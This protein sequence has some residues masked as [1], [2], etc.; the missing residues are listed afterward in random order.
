VVLAVPMQKKWVKPEQTHKKTTAIY[1]IGEPLHTFFN[2]I[3]HNEERPF[4]I[5]G[6]LKPN[7]WFNHDDSLERITR[8]FNAYPQICGVYTDFIDEKPY[9]LDQ[10]SPNL[11]PLDV[12]LFIS[13]RYKNM[14]EF[15]AEQPFSNVMFQ[16]M[17]RG[18]IM[19][20]I[21]EQLLCKYE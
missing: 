13:S 12:C 8:K 6:F 20:H 19:I 17:Q 5:Y 15:S 3:L 7:Y 21:A 11:Q 1:Q 10:Y 9:Y 18:L 16:I 2:N 14:I 4:D